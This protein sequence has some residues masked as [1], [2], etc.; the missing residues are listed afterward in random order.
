VSRNEDG[1]ITTK[2]F[3]P[4]Q[5]SDSMM[6]VLGYANG[7]SVEEPKAESLKSKV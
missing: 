6:R 1:E 3:A 7:A 2:L 4:E 5:S